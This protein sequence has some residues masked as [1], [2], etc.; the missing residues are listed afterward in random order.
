MARAERVG[1]PGV[2]KRREARALLVRE[3]G[4]PAVGTGVLEVYLLV[5]H[6]EVSAGHNRLLLRQLAEELPV[7]R[8][9]LKTLVNAGQAVL[10][11]GRVDVHKPVP[12]K[13]Q[14]ADA[15]LVISH[16]AAYL[17]HHPQRLLARE[18]R[19]PGVALALCVVPSLII[20]RQ[21]ELQLALL[22]LGLLQGKDIGVQLAKD[23]LEAGV[24]LHHGTQS[25]DV[26]RNKSQLAGGRHGA[27]YRH[28]SNRAMAP[29]VARPARSAFFSPGAA[30]PM[31]W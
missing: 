16:R 28:G 22:E 5:G 2:K 10:G 24:L 29:S 9:P 11:V 8:V 4:V 20:T 23:L 25:V 18:D 26:P 12:V 1:E 3:S 13:L 6:V 27:P 30:G 19:R 21:V 14:R 31:R 17:P 15:P 7:A